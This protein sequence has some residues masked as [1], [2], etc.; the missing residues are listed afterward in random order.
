MINRF[1]DLSST[2]RIASPIPKVRAQENTTDGLFEGMSSAH[3]DILAKQA[4]ESKP[5]A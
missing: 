3:W 1:L 2:E 5:H 4:Q